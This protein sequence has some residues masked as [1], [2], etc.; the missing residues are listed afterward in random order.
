M[1]CILSLCLTL[2]LAADASQPPVG[3]GPESSAPAA[4]PAAA[5][6]A[7]QPAAPAPAAVPAPAPAGQPVAPADQPQGQ[8]PP[9]QGPG[10]GTM[11]WPIIIMLVVMWFLV[12]RPQKKYQRE[13]KAM[14]DAVKKRDMAITRGGIIGTVV[15]VKPDEI[16]LEIAKNVRVRVRRAAVEGILP[17]E[18]PETSKE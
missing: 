10:L 15:E 7:G 1:N 2:L 3:P 11:L 5:V 9:D 12:M 6:P 16:L 14:L 8:V 13:R 4:A 17:P 18:E